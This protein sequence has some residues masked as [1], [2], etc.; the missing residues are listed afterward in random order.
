MKTSSQTSQ[1][2]T[3]ASKSFSP[4][5]FATAASPPG[6]RP[7]SPTFQRTRDATRQSSTLD[8]THAH[9]YHACSRAPEEPR[10][11]HVFLYTCAL[12]RTHAGSRA[13]L[14]THAGRRRGPHCGA[15]SAL[16]ATCPDNR[17][18]PRHLN[19]AIEVTC[20]ATPTQ[21]DHPTR[22]R[23]GGGRSVKT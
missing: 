4:K 2:T 3:T 6:T 1:T 12:M 14:R 13:R 8:R 10:V 17:V 20:S 22:V 7:A 5:G 9:Q 16:P 11:C 15:P 19:R 21:F 18:I 23:S